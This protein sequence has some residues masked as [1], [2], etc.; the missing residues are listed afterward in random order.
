M[1]PFRMGVVV[2]GS[3]SLG[4]FRRRCGG[5]VSLC[6]FRKV[7]PLGLV[8]V[9]GLVLVLIRTQQGRSR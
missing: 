8:V 5:Q 2:G 3:V 4:W 6:W 1:L 9:M 7:F